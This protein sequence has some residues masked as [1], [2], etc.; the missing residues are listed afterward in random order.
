MAGVQ[1]QGHMLVNGS[2][3]FFF[4]HVVD[5]VKFLHLDNKLSK[6]VGVVP[7]NN[8]GCAETPV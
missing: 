1:L 7:N 2:N 8:R 4:L 3:A 5:D 6:E